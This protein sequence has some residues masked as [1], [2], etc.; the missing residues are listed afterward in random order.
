MGNRPIFHGQ[1]AGKDDSDADLE[2]YVRELDKGLWKAIT[3]RGS[4]VVLAASE[5]VEPVF[6]A[7]TRLPSLVE[8]FLHGN[9]ERASDEE[10]HALALELI[11][12]RFA[13]RIDEAKG[14]LC[15]LLGTGIATTE[16]EQVV[17]AAADG[18]IDTL[19]VRE[20][21]HVPGSFDP[22]THRVVLGD[23]ARAST[24]LLDRAA[25][26]TFLA[27]GT[28]YRLDPA[29]MPVESEAAAILRY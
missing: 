29:H 2:K 15:D 1:G 23:G 20:G 4:P 13:K 22:E 17:V 26:D 5:Q 12:P 3:H 19:F 28:V 24:D 16:V 8:P 9:F 7:H 11:E 14:R 27:G 25:T 21:A 10:L 6:R 18:K